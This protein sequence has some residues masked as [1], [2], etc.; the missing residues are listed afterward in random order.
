MAGFGAPTGAVLHST[1]Y[2]TDTVVH[3]GKAPEWLAPSVWFVEDNPVT[4]S[5]DLVTLTI[6]GS[7]P[8][9]QQKQGFYKIKSL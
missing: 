1:H 5:S 4:Q 9:G 2:S 3:Y 7:T 6:N 8:Q